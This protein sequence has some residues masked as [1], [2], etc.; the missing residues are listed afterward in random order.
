MIQ[1]IHP[2]ASNNHIFKEYWYFRADNTKPS[3]RQAFQTLDEKSFGDRSFSSK[4]P[5]KATW[6]SAVSW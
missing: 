1:E 4:D 5:N 6:R 3:P 2:P